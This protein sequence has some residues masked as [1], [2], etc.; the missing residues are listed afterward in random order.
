MKTLN[1]IKFKLA[2]LTGLKFNSLETDKGEL[3]YDGEELAP[4]T[5][6]YMQDAEGNPVDVSDG[7]YV[8][9]TKIIT[10]MDSKVANVVDRN[11]IDSGQDM[12]EDI[13]VPDE[14]PVTETVSPEDYNELVKTVNDVVGHIE[15]IEG[16]VFKRLDKL[17][18][19]F[20][21][22]E[23]PAD[24]PIDSISTNEKTSLSPE[25]RFFK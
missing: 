7:E 15:R 8:S 21:K 20:S 25:E 24:K 17:Q 22:V 6:V 14:L 18:A 13:E 23:K 10:V 3:Y 1:K 11:D 4:G 9:E 2:K 12:Q 5:E 19:E 16:E